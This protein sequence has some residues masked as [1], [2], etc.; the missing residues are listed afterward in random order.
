MK[1]DDQQRQGL[2][3]LLNEADLLG[4]EVGPESKI[5]TATFNVLTLPE[6]GPA[7]KDSRYQMLFYPV[8]R[9]VA[10]LRQTECESECEA[11]KTFPLDELLSVVQ[12]F[13]G[14]PI[15][16]WSFFDV[17]EKTLA[18]MAGAVSLDWR[19]GDESMCHS[20]SVFQEGEGRQLDLCVW[21][22]SL[23]IRNP[24]GEKVPLDA[25]IAGAERWWNAMYAGDARTD[26]RGIVPAS[27]VKMR[28]LLGEV[29]D[30]LRE[31]FR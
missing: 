22:D 16:G 7:P 10:S 13:G 26:G 19:S 27:S 14:Q 21:F 30:F 1:L 23:A 9:V 11:V 2:N 31:R 3:T 5:G 29:F 28:S 15:Y 24:N 8:K 17:H 25:A 4:F 12:S 6:A 20:I 18:Q